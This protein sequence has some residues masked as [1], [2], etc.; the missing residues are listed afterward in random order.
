MQLPPCTGRL[1]SRTLFN[2]C[3]FSELMLKSSRD[4]EEPLSLACAN[5]VYQSDKVK[6]KKCNFL[7]SIIYFYFSVFQMLYCLIYFLTF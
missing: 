7:N 6:K 3:T 5:K 1:R 4:I 2:K